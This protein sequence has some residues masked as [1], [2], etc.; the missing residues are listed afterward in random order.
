MNVLVVHNYYQ[1][2]GG[3]DQVFEAE[4]RLLLEGG[5][6]VRTHAVRND[7]IEEQGRART[8]M[9]TIWNSR[10][11]RDLAEI[12]RRERVDVVHFH[13]TFPLISPAAYRAVRARGAAVVQTL[14]NYRLACVNGVL[15]RDGRV[16]VSCVGRGP[17][18]GVRHACYRGSRAGSAVAATMLATHRLLGT[19]ARHVDRYVALTEFSRDQLAQAGLPHERITVKPNFLPDDPGAGSGEGGYALFVGRLTPEKGLGTLLSAWRDGSPGVPLRIVGTGPM[20]GEVAAAAQET[21]GVEFLGRLERAR[22]LDLMRGAGVL[23]FPSEWYETFGLTIIEAYAC[24][25]PVVASDIGSPVSLVKHGVTGRHFRTGD[26]GDLAAQ[27][28]AVVTSPDLPRYRQEARRAYEEAF[29]PEE[30]YR[31]LMC[32]YDDAIQARAGKTRVPAV[33]P[34]A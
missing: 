18:S 6:N 2:A 19:Y 16:C 34:G 29:T 26:A 15:Y 9:Q 33:A 21:P 31:R 4:T 5:V 24:G 23:V 10:A 30:G 1:Q 28:R 14:H 12:V 11:A 25:T 27:V 8:A 22:V 20:E 13:N 17:W 7:V 32:V 3:E